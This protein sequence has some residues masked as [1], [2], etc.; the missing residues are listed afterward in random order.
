GVRPSPAASRSR[1]SPPSFAPL[2]AL[3]QELRQAGGADAAHRGLHVVFEAHV[4]ERLS[5]LVV[6]HV[7]R[8]RVAVA[9]LADAAHRDQVAVPLLHPDLVV[10]AETQVVRAAVEYAR[11]VRVPDEAHALLERAEL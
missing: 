2:Q 5:A 8:A 7:A 4:A 1:W 9:R 3:G 6:E 10:A 11:E